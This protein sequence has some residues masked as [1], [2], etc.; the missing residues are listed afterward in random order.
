MSE[1]SEELRP[2]QRVGGTKARKPGGRSLLREHGFS[3]EVT[4]Y[5]RRIGAIP[6]KQFDEFVN[7]ARPPSISVAAEAGIGHSAFGTSRVQSSE[8][9]RILS[10]SAQVAGVNLRRFVRLFCHRFPARSLAQGLSVG[11]AALALELVQQALAWLADFQINLPARPVA[12]PHISPSKTKP[13]RR[14]RRTGKSRR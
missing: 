11:E 7:R 1:L 14:S 5:I 12:T 4:K 8:A 13:T 6:T 10:T 9:W 3:K 2:T